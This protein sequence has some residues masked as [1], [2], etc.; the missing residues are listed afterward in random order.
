MR[1]GRKPVYIV[2]GVQTVTTGEG[3][4]FNTD[5]SDVN[6]QQHSEVVPIATILS[7]PGIPIPLE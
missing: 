1:R 2:T 6:G 3:D 5:Y 7:L 4:L